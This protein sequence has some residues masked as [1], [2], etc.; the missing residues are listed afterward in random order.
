MR[1]YCRLERY[2][3]DLCISQRYRAFG[4]Q[5]QGI[6]V[7]QALGRHVAARGHWFPSSRAHASLPRSMQQAC[8]DGGLAYIGVGTGDEISLAHSG[9]SKTA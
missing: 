3:I 7:A 2:R 8:R 1:C 6:A 4:Q 9:F 5:C